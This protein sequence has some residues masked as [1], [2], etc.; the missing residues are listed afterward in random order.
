MSS[1]GSTSTTATVTKTC[2]ASGSSTGTISVSAGGAGSSGGIAA[3]SSISAGGLVPIT[4]EQFSKLMEAIQSTQS[5]LDDKLADFKA[6]VC[7]SQEEA[8]AK[9]VKRSKAAEKPYV[10]KKKG[11]EAQ[12]KFNSEVEDSVNDALG[13]LEG[14]SR[15]SKAVTE[16]K[17]ALEQGLKKLAERQ[18]LIKLADRSEFGWGVV[19]EYTADELADGSDD[20]KK[21]EKAEKAAEKKA[22]K[23]KRAAS[24]RVTV[25]A[26]RSS[27][28]ATPSPHSA[29]QV[30]RRPG[31]IPAV[32]KARPLGPCFC[33]GEMGH[34]QSFCSKREGQ[35]SIKK[36]YPSNSVMCLSSSSNTGN[37]ASDST[38]PV[39]VVDELDDVI[40]PHVDRRAWEVEGVS[41][42][43]GDMS[44]QGRLKEK[45]QFWRE[46]LSAP[47]SVLSTI[48]S[49]Y[50]LPLKSEPTPN[51]QC[52]QQSAI[53]NADFV[54]Q[55][56]SDL[57]RNRCVRQVLEVPCVCSP[58]SVVESSGGKKRL[59]INLR[60]LN[61]F[62]WKQKFK[63]EDIRVAMLLFEKGD[64][65]FS[66]DLKSGYHHV[67]IA[68][69]H[70]KYLGFSW[71][72][73]Y[74]VF[75][76][77]PFGL[78]TACYMFTKLLRPLVRYWREQGIRI[79]VY[80]DD[81]LAAAA[82]EAN[83]IKASEIVHSTLEQAGFRA[84]C[85]KSVWEP[86]QRLQWLGFVLD[87]AQGQIE[88]PQEKIVQLL[89]TLRQAAQKPK[90]SA[91]SLAS[92]VGRIISMGLAV[93]P[94]S[95]FM[96]RSL[97]ALLESRQMW[98]GML[99]LSE[100]ARGELDFWSANLAEYKTQPIWH[101]PSAV[102]VV[103]SDASDTG[104]GGYVVEHGHYVAYGQ[105]TLSE[106][107]QSSTWRELT[108]VWRVLQSLQKKLANLCIRWFSDNQNVVRILQVGSRQPHLQEIALKIFALSINSHIHLQPEWVPRELNEQAD[109]L[110]RIVDLDD[111]MLNPWIFAQ[112]DALW[113]PY[114]VDRFASCD[115]TQLPR[116]NSR[117]WN[118]GSEAVDAF[119]VN[120]QGE[121][122][123]WCPP[124]VL[125]PRV[126]PACTGMC[127]PRYSNCSLLA[128]CSILA[129]SMSM[130]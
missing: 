4:N 68:T 86:T 3:G 33:C 51:I 15:P 29:A 42:V 40:E 100:E 109:Y 47:S 81:G 59:V 128:I 127:C 79:V 37:I 130:W 13:E 25:P 53:V 11:N 125:I 72:G 80:L 119:T 102:R 116:F 55:S 52:N 58:L 111:W 93:G 45:I 118:P 73:A 1:S 87:L 82:G 50:V 8:A 98:C 27:S 43:C 110:S 49:G 94:V 34:I 62:L 126:H 2:S 107:R 31:L 46:V 92:I 112:L 115:N 19:A 21:I 48:E 129:H 54:Q 20:E 9:A 6:Q 95:R 5:S 123:W 41:P 64:F 90:L 121:N 22:A 39:C 85:E 36:W 30:P 61:R 74:Y 120:W 104:Y 105:W 71:Q 38:V 24:S 76:V 75:T 28:S 117:C 67:D 63:Y 122:N 101:S 26:K 103:Y 32:A 17:A 35:V 56:L 7:Q 106:S 91:K 66:F 114:T 113:G 14:E 65:M 89:D 96:T 70:Q 88:V 10:F 124:I 23:R 16:A 83:A 69:I 84:N 99:T 12:A 108:A 78:S 97:Y 60:H 77:L 18:K 57:I 44:V